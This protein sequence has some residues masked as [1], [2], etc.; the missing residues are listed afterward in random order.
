[1]INIKCPICHVDI[2]NHSV[3]ET[4]S[5]YYKLCDEKYFISFND[6]FNYSF[7]LNDHL[8][9]LIHLKTFSLILEEDCI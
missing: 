1:M 8:I 7:Y 6:R 9:E 2:E 3:T 4:P 5:I